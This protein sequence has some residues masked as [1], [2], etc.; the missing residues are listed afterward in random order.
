MHNGADIMTTRAIDGIDA[1]HASQYRAEGYV[2]VR[3]VFSAGQIAELDAEA[4]RLRERA[5]LID[6]DNIRCRWQ[7]DVNTG[8]CRFD[9]FDPVIDLSPACER[10]ARDPRLL[11][12]VGTLYGEPACLFKDK[13]IFKSPG[14]PGY[15]LHQDY[16]SWESFP[17][18]FLTVI[19]AIDASDAHNGAT[20]VF[21]RYHHQGCLSPRDGMYHQMS[22]DAVDLSTGVVLDLAPGDIAIFSGYTPHRS[23]ANHSTRWRRLLYLSYN[24]FSDGGEQRD[25]HYA[26]FHAWLRDRYAEYGKTLTFFR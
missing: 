12:C 15:K 2:V 7:N 22:E 26:E 1:A 8:E 3:Q 4:L 18:S 11:D 20:E 9:C 19:L 23:G 13:L 24:A 21:P 5:D 17:T 6:V 10:A 14:T 25:R 16:I